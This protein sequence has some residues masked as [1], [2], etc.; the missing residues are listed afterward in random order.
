MFSLIYLYSYIYNNLLLL[1]KYIRL[2][3]EIT[4]IYIYICNFHII[5]ILENVLPH[6]CLSS[7]S[8]N[9]M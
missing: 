6:L 1:Y 4:Y 9:Y 7:L 5:S 3:F 2:L 8:E